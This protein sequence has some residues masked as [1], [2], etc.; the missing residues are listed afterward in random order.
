MNIGLLTNSEMKKY[1][2]ILNWAMDCLAAKSC[3]LIEQPQII[4]ET[5][6]S[7]VIR[8]PSLPRDFYLKQP[9]PAFAKEADIIELLA[10]QFNASV[11]HIMAK[12]LDLHCFL[13]NDAG[14]SLRHYMSDGGKS[15]LLSQAIKYF[16][17]FQRSTENYIKPFLQLG[18]PHWGL[19]QLPSMYEKIS[20]DTKFLK[21][22]GVTEDELE[23]IHGLSPVVAEQCHLLSEYG[24]G[25]TVVQPDCNTNNILINPKT[26]E[27]TII[28]LGELA[29]SHPFFSLHNFL[30]HATIHHSVK[31]QDK[32][33]NA[34]VVACIKPWFDLLPRAKLLEG[35]NLS[36]KLWPVYSACVHYHFMHCVDIH[37][38]NAWYSN[39]PN[40]LAVIFRKCINTYF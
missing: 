10:R 40:R 21:A 23:K 27:F 9:V 19:K 29:I 28:D 4:Q 1:S 7:I 30:H 3:Y 35:F 34:M 6:W 32:V 24:I 15:S 5:P 12:N 2:N 39:T 38:L 8:L 26:Q 18:I 33:W 17:A 13:M 16:T 37:A 25:E 11:P 36:K 22:N 31:E 20:N 14:A